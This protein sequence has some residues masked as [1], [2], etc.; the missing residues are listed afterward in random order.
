[1]QKVLDGKSM[2]DLT[3]E[4]RTTMMTKVQ[5]EAKKAGIT[6]P[7][8]F[9]AGGRGGNRGEQKG[10][11]QTAQGGGRRGG[12]GGPGGVPMLGMSGQNFKQSDMD[13]AKLPPPPEEDNQ[14]DVLLRPGLLADVEIIVEKIPNAINVPAQAVFQKDNKMVVYVKEGG[15]FVPREIRI[16]K[17]SENVFVIDSGVKPGEEIAMADPD[18]KPGDKKKDGKGQGG[19]A[20]GTM[21]GGKKG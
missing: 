6:L 11:E 3:P 12:A 1:M 9:G 7:A 2:Q 10:G 17:R 21:P 18:A 4:E 16:K 20:V 5:E 15:K 14:L 19:G 13:N 8:G